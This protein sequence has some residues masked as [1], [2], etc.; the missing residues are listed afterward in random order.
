MC[1]VEVMHSL[2]CVNAIRK[3]LSPEYYS[4]HDMHALPEE[5]QQIHVG[6][7]TARVQIWYA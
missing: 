1:R 7:P 5:L 4:V 3:A 2:H 6:K